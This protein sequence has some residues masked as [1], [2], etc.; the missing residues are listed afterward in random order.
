MIN[1]TCVAYATPA[2]Q[3]GL[4]VLRLSGGTAAQIADHVFYPGS[5]P[6][7]NDRSAFSSLTTVRRMRGYTCRFGHVFDPEEL[8]PIDEAV[9]TR[10]V[11]PR[12]YTGEDVVE[13]SIHGGQ[14]VRNALLQAV[15]K[16]GAR[17]AEPGEFTRRAFLNGKLDLAQAE[18][19]M[20]LIN[21]EADSRAEAALGQLQGKL[22]SYIHEIR[23]PLL[24]TMAKLELAI[25]YPEHEESVISPESLRKDIETA[26]EKLIALV[27]TYHD[28]RVIR[29][30]LCV[31]LAGRPNSGK[32]TLLNTLSGYDRAIVTDIP[33]T[34]RDTI[35]ERINLSGHAITVID[36]AG[37]RATT[38][39]VER[40]GVD[41][42]LKAMQKA[43]LI[44]WLFPSDSKSL[45]EDLAELKNFSGN[46]TILPLISKA[47]LLNPS[48]LPRYL[49]N[50]RIEA[51]HAAIGLE[52]LPPI[53]VSGL[54]KSGIE[55]LIKQIIKLFSNGE[56][57]LHSDGVL[58]T[59]ERHFLIVK[60]AA[61][62]MCDLK[63]NLTEL[64]LDI[65]SLML[66][67]IA[68][69]LAEITGENVTDEVWREIFA[70]FCVGK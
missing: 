26:T 48:D 12:S 11:A 10:F 62:L 30:G 31:L 41:R 55:Q 20:D 19:V 46:A 24:S 65:I 28:G 18:A 34:T 42:S 60:K 33:G 64:P 5:W 44:L 49:E 23:E 4:A 47:D 61:E 15:V 25:Q 57:I 70:N 40:L 22:S 69:T 63:R 37:L 3:A 9:L 56:R 6:A 14:A 59:A 68:E 66:Q 52:F 27:A 32:S 39:T 36:T 7:K 58:L 17:L 13:I 38:D 21:A 16:A 8:K 45:S 2:G 50:L 51:T 43:D 54:D 67:N 29:D 53:A 1:D 35:E